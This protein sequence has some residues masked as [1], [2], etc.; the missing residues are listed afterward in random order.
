ML[1]AVY[2]LRSWLD[3]CSLAGVPGIGA[4]LVLVPVGVFAAR[5]RRISV[6]LVCMV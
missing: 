1:M 4:G 6:S 5:G 2:G 3:E